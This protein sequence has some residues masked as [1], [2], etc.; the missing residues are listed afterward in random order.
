MYEYFQKAMFTSEFIAALFGT[1]YF[2]KYKNT[3]IKILLPLLWYIPINEMVCQY[4]FPRTEMG[5]LLYNFYDVIVP[6]TILF[7]LKNQTILKSRKNKV[8]VLLAIC[9]TG[10]LVSL[11]FFNPLK[12][13]S[14]WNFTMFT[15]LVI[16]GLLIYFIDLLN[17]DKIFLLRKN[18]FLIVNLGFLI[19]F[20]GYPVI[21][22]AREVVSDAP[23]IN[24]ILNNIQFTVAIL[25]Y[26]IIAFGFYQG[27][28][29]IIKKQK[30]NT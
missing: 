9:I 6:A 3:Q 17:S 27:E 13:F 29:M 16:N 22:L 20:V 28:K 2:Y 10:F 1:F 12:E 25:S 30:I 19:F 15:F 23:T 24:G 18:L 26:L 7:M 4:I 8:R 5:Y 21:S 11:F 14:K